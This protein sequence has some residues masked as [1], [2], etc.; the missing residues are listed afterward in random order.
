MLL[1]S[2][3]FVIWTY[4]DISKKRSL[5]FKEQYSNSMSLSILLRKNISFVSKCFQPRIFSCQLHLNVKSLKDEKSELPQDFI[6]FSTSEFHPKNLGLQQSQVITEKKPINYT[7]NL[8]FSLISM[9]AFAYCVYMLKFNE[10][11]LDL[12][13]ENR[14]EEIIP[15]YQRRRMQN[16]PIYK[17]KLMKLKSEKE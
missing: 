12:E 13:E 14:I 8:I 2:A 16:D 6:K 17:E 7:K 10:M 11:A 1:F 3:Y 15:G 9:M 4:I 5:V